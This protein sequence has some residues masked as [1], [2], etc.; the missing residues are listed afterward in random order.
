MKKISEND[1]F[2]S[3]RETFQNQQHIYLVMEYLERGDLFFYLKQRENVFS[4]EIIKN[5]AA[6]II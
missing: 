4:E 2:V 6:E 1:I 5:I 3:I